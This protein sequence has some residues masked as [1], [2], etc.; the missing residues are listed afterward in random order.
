MHFLLTEGCFCSLKVWVRNRPGSTSLRRSLVRIPIYQWCTSTCLAQLT[1][2]ERRLERFGLLLVLQNGKKAWLCVYT[3]V[4][5]LNRYLRELRRDW[6]NNYE[7][8]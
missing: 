1:V 3:L 5:H 4:R 6:N 8:T 2:E 7:E